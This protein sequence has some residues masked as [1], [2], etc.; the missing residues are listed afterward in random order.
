MR[1]TQFGFDSGE[2]IELSTWADL[3][4]DGVTVDSS[5]FARLDPAPATPS[6]LPS[7]DPP[8]WGRDAADMARISFQPP[9]QL[10]FRARTLLGR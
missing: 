6:E 8:E 4:W 10:A 7:D 9:F 2:P 5:P 1:G 3:T